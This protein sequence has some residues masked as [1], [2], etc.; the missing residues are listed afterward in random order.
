MFDVADL[1]LDLKLQGIKRSSLVELYFLVERS[2]EKLLLE[3]LVEKFKMSCLSLIN[4]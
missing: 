2:G 4:H 3:V 1:R